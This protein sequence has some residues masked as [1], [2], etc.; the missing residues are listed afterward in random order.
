M[1]TIFVNEKEQKRDWYVIDA[2]GKPLGRV[3][4]KAAY[5]ARGKN[6]ATYTP[7][8]EMGDYVVIINADK[9]AVSGG[10]ETKKI[11]YK[12]TTGFV[13]SLKANSFEKVI[14]KHP[15]DPIRLAVKGMLPHGRLGRALMQ[16]VKI[17]A[18]TD[19][20]HTAQNPKAVEL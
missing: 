19:H 3:A 16:N 6:K 13:G 9:V 4:A 20:P 17:Y 5:I 8:Q 1:K 14:E 10:K 18:G 2:A 7:N 15:E 12:Y 11:Y